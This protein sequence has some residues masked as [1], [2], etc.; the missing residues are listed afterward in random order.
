MKVKYFFAYSPL[1]PSR[2]NRRSP[3]GV[4]SL[5]KQYKFG[6]LNW[7][8]LKV[9]FLTGAFCRNYNE[10]VQNQHR[11]EKSKTKSDFAVN[12]R[13]AADIMGARHRR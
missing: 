6:V 8:N 5:S 9:E 4:I 12:L 7:K 13:I 10:T 11:S 1:P 3:F 2:R